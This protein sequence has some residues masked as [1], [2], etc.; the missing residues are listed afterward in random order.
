MRL[1]E[2]EPLKK[3]DE[4]RYAQGQANLFDTDPTMDQLTHLLGQPLTAL[5]LR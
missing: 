2:W 4:Q 1:P 3:I 5:G